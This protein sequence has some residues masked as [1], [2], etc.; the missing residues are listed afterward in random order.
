MSRNFGKKNRKTNQKAESNGAPRV[1]SGVGW[2][3]LTLSAFVGIVTIECGPM[4]F[5]RVVRH[6]M[7]VTSPASSHKTRVM[8]HTPQHLDFIPTGPDVPRFGCCGPDVL[9]KVY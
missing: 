6:V 2:V 7:V 3:A 4:V 9:Y 5:T 8:C 1:I